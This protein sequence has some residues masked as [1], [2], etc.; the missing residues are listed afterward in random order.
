VIYYFDT[1]ALVKKYAVETGTKQVVGLFG[2]DVPAA[3]SILTY[4]ELI[5]GV[6]RKKRDGEIAEKDHRALLA[7]FEA[8]WLAF[9]IVEFQDALLPIQKRLSSRHPLKG[10][11]LVH[12]SSLLWLKDASQEDVALVASDVQLLQAAKR[13][14]VEIINP[15]A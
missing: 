8:D 6:G 12:L 9:L 5:A 14:G 13:E 15:E 10:A 11:D 2:E 3:T 4:P 1:S 7:K